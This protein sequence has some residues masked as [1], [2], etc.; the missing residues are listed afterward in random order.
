MPPETYEFTTRDGQN[1]SQIL[2]QEYGY[3]NSELL[4]EVLDLNQGLA[5]QPLVLPI[6]IM[7]I[8][9]VK[10]LPAVPTIPVQTL[11]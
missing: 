9:P 7:I 2:V 11:W 4:F 6:D 3:V 1:L 5:E 10:E 8:L